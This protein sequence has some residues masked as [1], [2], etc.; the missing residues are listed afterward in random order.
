[1]S[2][3]LGY[4]DSFLCSPHLIIFT[5]YYQFKRAVLKVYT[6]VSL[7]S[8]SL[9]QVFYVNIRG[10]PTMYLRTTYFGMK[11]QTFTEKWS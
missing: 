10:H 9:K 11:G 5:S 2:K 8:L 1:M 6:T 4:I 3:I 7:R